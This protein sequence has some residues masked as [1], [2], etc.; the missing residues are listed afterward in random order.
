MDG[1]L[2]G[3]ADSTAMQARAAITPILFQW[4]HWTGSI[5]H[6]RPAARRGQ[7]AGGPEIAVDPEAFVA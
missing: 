5:D 3:L 6:R 2:G 1:C 4:Y 7:A